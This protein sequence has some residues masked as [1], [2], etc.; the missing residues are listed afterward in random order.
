MAFWRCG[1]S[2]CQRSSG[3]GCGELKWEEASDGTPNDRP[4]AFSKKTTAAHSADA[5]GAMGNEQ[6][7]GWANEE[8]GEGDEDHPFSLHLKMDGVF[9][10]KTPKRTFVSLTDFELRFLFY[11]VCL[12]AP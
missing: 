3:E 6:T 1:R 8:K 5:A 11:A 9:A 2:F 7:T 10:I 12:S 4:T